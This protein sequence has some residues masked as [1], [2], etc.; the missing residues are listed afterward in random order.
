MLFYISYGIAAGFIVYCLIR[1]YKGEAR[2]VHP[3][4]WI[5]TGL[6]V[7]NFVVMALI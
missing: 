1:I 2:A 7:L 5:F 4:M 3:L 6:F